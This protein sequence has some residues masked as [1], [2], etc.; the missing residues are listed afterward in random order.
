[1][2]QKPKNYSNDVK[3]SGLNSKWLYLCS[4]LS[5]DHSISNQAAQN[6][7]FV[8]ALIQ[9]KYSLHKM[10]RLVLFLFTVKS[11]SLFS[12]IYRFSWYF[13]TFLLNFSS[14]LKNTKILTFFSIC[15]LLRSLK[16]SGHKISIEGPQ[17][18][19]LC[20]KIKMSDLV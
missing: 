20:I 11:V 14:T 19:S 9:T 15:K 17:N 7:H 2:H 1:M 4:L 8:W 18:W 10:K 6:K 12:W 5:L 13:S 3:L 16:E